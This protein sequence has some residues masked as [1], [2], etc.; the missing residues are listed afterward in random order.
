MQQQREQPR[1]GVKEKVFPISCSPL[2]AMATQQHKQQ[3]QQGGHDPEIFL[4]TAPDRLLCPVCCMV[5]R[6][7]LLVVECGHHFCMSCLE[8]VKW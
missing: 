7:P 3:Q 8:S 1:N 2:A 4:K 5:M 6:E